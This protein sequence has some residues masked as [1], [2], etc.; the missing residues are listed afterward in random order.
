MPLDVYLLRDPLLSGLLGRLGLMEGVVVGQTAVGGS[1]GR[2]M[3]HAQT[4]DGRHTHLRNSR[5]SR[6]RAQR[7]RWS[8]EAI[9]ADSERADEALTSVPEPRRTSVR[10]EPGRGAS[11]QLEPT[12]PPT[13]S[14]CSVHRQRVRPP[15]ATDRR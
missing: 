13:A 2:E 3:Q 12:L 9:A 11:Y 4:L 10:P 8:G 1:E 15:R 5:T 6:V 7:M 14:S